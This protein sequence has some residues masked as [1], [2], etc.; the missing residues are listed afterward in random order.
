MYVSPAF[1]AP[2]VLAP[3]REFAH[4]TLSARRSRPTLKASATNPTSVPSLSR[5]A[6]LTVLAATS[7][8]P[9]LTDNILLPTQAE[10]A[11]A[12]PTSSFSLPP[13][14]Y[15][16]DAL[17]PH[18]SEKIMHFHHDMHFNT[19][20]KNLNAALADLP[21]PPTTDKALRT[22]LADL[23][24]I[25]DSA[26]RTRV[27]NNGGGYLNHK[28][29]FSQMT[30]SGRALRS[31][32]AITKAIES[33]FGSIDEFKTKF[34]GAA[35]TLFGSGFTWL[36]RTADGK[37]EIVQTPNQDN[38]VMNGVTPVLGCDCWEH[39]WYT[40]YGP[41]K[42]DYL[43]EWWSVVDWVAVNDAFVNAAHDL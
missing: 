8:A 25:P 18:I 39:A 19:Y 27:R 41:K 11:P 29:F 42:A 23:S 37:L 38:P 31:D 3:T 17:E 21:N 40:Q 34:L 35:T 6:F 9:L 43:P 5:R 7:V 2:C 4:P 20:V 36:V 30:P 32:L 1:Q 33:K 28:Q 22:L 24:V 26:I 13:L 14:P 12:V 15:G 16:Y 10:T